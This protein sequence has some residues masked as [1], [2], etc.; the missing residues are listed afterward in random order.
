MWTRG[1]NEIVYQDSQGRI[2][3]AAVR[4]NGNELDF[5]RAEALFTFASDAGNSLYRRFDGTSD[6]ER[7]LLLA[8]EGASGSNSSLE[9]ILIQNWIEEL[10]RLVP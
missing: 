6:G 4:G 9:L 7:F 10:K 2:M 1:G 3:A 5:S 8:N